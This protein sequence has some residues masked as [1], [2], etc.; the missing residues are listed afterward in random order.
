[1]QLWWQQILLIFLR[2]DVIFV[3]KTTLISYGVTV[4]I[5]DCQCKQRKNVPEE[6]FSWCSRY[7]CPM[8]VGAYVGVCHIYALFG[9]CCGV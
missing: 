2:T 1:M 4:C 9:G 6:L 5:I 8:E 7:H 3:T